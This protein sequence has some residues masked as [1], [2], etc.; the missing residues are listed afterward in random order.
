MNSRPIN[1]RIN[2]YRITVVCLLITEFSDVSP[3][4]FATLNGPEW[5]EEM[6]QRFRARA[7]MQRIQIQHPRTDSQLSIISITRDSTPSGF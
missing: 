7:L 5:A 6:T 2:K 4:K 3:L 1:L